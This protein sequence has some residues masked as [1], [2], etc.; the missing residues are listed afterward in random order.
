MELFAFDDDYV[1]RLRAG[2]RK[3]SEHFE[4]Y[5]RELL[6]IKLRRRLRSLDAIEDVRQEVFV[7]VFAKLDELRDGRKLGA[8]VNAVCQHVLME[9]YRDRD[10]HSRTDLAQPE[11]PSD[12]AGIEQELVDEER[13]AR[14]RR[15]L[16]RLPER[17]YDIL[18]ALF[19]EEL[20]KDEVC[21]RFGIDRN[22]LRVL[23]HR[24]KEKFR[25]EF[26]RKSS[27]NFTVTI[28][29]SSSLSL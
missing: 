9:H 8:F 12:A 6:L 11:T 1:R 5:F 10:R 23:L 19:L 28:G 15:V 2:D 21:R 3:T 27:P 13:R 26:R 14:V 4:A 22:Y 7:R 29:G 20:G 18:K 16:Q 25:S 24:A 17:D